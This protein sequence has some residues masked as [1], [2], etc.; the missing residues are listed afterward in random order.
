M[1]NR[2]V[3]HLRSM[4]FDISEG[5]SN[6]WAVIEVSNTGLAL[7]SIILAPVSL[8]E[9]Y[10]YDR[11]SGVYVPMRKPKWSQGIVGWGLG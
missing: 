11:D 7:P 5:G 3:D 10:R 2:F 4:I 1:L 8:E 6:D 9:W